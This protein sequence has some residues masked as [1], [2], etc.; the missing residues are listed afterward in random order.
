M[1]ERAPKRLCTR[2]GWG[3][4]P[5]RGT[6]YAELLRVAG[7][8][9]GVVTSDQLHAAGLRR[10]TISDWVTCGRLFRR[11]TGVYLL[12]RPTLE[13]LG[14]EWAAALLCDGAGALDALSALSLWG[15]HKPPATPTV[16]VVGRDL[17]SRPGITTHRS[18]TLSPDD[19]RICHGLPLTSPARSILDA[20]PLLGDDLEQTIATARRRKLL[21]P[22]ELERTL[23]RHPGRPG[24][25]RIRNILAR[26]DKYT[27]SKAE[28]LMLRLARD[29]GLPEPR[30]NV[31]FENIELDFVWQEQRLVVEIDG[32]EFHGGAKA[33][34]DDR[35]RDARLVA[36]GY[37]VIR[38]TWLQ[39]TQQPLKVIA[40]IAQ[41]LART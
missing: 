29:A 16:T 32:E 6:G 38:F 14:A 34:Q 2:I 27:R 1:P 23:E 5:V 30:T 40:R 10:S 33:F 15:L 36:A 21:R 8:Q 35:D 41:A 7:F 18:T 20:A 11:F 12:G 22:G 25:D 19:L 24:I 13:P 26:G 3:P 17:R 9:C 37:R 4:A 39:L 28:R 31:P